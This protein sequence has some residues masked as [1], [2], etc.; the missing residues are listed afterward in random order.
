M[1]MLWHIAVLSSFGL[2]YEKYGRI[3]REKFP[4]HDFPAFA[5]ITLR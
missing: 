1:E 2:G 3:L 5:K 4:P